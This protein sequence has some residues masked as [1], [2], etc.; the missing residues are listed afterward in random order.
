[1]SC[2]LR[3]DGTQPRLRRFDT[4]DENFKIPEDEEEVGDEA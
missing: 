3:I 2:K 1:M 4:E